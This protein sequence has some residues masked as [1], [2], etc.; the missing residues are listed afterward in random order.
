MRPSL[1]LCL[2]FAAGCTQPITGLQNERHGQPVIPETAMLPYPSDLWLVEDDTAATGVHVDF[3]EALLEQAEPHWFT[4]ADGFSRVSPLLTWFP[5]GVDG[6]TL[7]SIAESVTADS[8]V[9]LVNLDSGERVPALVELDMH[10]GNLA[11]QL[12]IIRPARAMRASTR[13]AVIIRDNL[14]LAD[15]ATP[16]VTRAMRALLDETPTD[17]EEV[18]ALRPAFDAVLDYLQAEEVEVASVLQAWTFSTRSE[19]QLWRAPLALHEAQWDAEFAPPTVD[20]DIVDEAAQLRILRG[21]YEAPYFLDGEDR[22]VVDDEGHPVQQGTQ[23]VE[24]QVTIPL[25]LDG[26]SRRPV[27]CYGHGFFSNKEEANRSLVESLHHWGMI[28]VSIDFDGFNAAEESE[29]LARL[30]RGLAELDIVVSQQLQAQSKFTGLHRLVTQHLA[31]QVEI[32]LGAG[33]YKPMDPDNVVY[34][35]I[36][37]GGTQGLSIMAASPA[38]ERGA[39]VVPGGGW[40]H[41]LQ[42]AVQWNSM[43]LLWEASFEDADEL[44]ISLGLAQQR[45]DAADSMN[46]ADRLVYDRMDGRDVKVSL[47]EALHDSQVANIVTHMVA[48]TADASM[49]TPSPVEIDLLDTVDGSNADIRAGLFVYAEDVTPAPTSNLPPDEDNRTHSTVRKLPAYLDQMGLFLEFGRF[50]Q[51]CDG[52]CDPD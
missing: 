9:W 22:L 38:F 49:L 31:D 52:A 46:F 3:G 2:V 36:S 28:A 34:A 23:T 33:L 50:E 51:V 37:N 47:H 1:L 20:E 27:V 45:F 40:S 8:S 25:T 30:G 24:Y 32:D 26:S 48:R 35:G 39:A 14:R 5:D 4:D 29:G 6:S 17:S 44:Q 10:T 18:E 15:G 12:L 42:R 21:T 16:R 7:P 13:H 43:G 41:M 19:E 11:R